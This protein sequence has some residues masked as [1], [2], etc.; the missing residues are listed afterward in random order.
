[1]NPIPLVIRLKAP[2]QESPLNAWILYPIS[3]ILPI[4]VPD[5]TAMSEIN[6]SNGK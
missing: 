6:W 4:I 5:R 3:Y 2:I 1:M